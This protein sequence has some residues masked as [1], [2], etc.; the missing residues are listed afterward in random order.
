MIAKGGLGNGLL[1]NVLGYD[2]HH[3]P[4]NARGR[5]TDRFKC[6]LSKLFWC[7]AFEHP[8]GDR[9]VHFLVV[10]F[11]KG[12]ATQIA[13]GDLADDQNHRHSILLSGMNSNRSI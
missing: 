12:F 5:H 1:L 2:E 10:D 13:C 11:L 9:A 3:R 8:F 4:R 6:G 7:L